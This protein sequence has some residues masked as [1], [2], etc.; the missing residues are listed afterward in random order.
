MFQHYNTIQCGVLFLSSQG[1]RRYC[2]TRKELLSIVYFVKY[3]KHYL[4]GH[5]FLVRTDHG[6]LRWLFNFR[7]PEKK[8]GSKLAFPLV[9]A[10]N[11]TI[12]FKPC[13]DIIYFYFKL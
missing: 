4:Y 13:R 11:T 1:E 12:N 6:A 2:V 10:C 8:S 7:S 5:K 9:F 3:F